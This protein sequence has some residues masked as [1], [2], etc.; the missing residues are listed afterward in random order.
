VTPETCTTQRITHLRRNWSC[1][2]SVNSCSS[3]GST[4]GVAR[5]DGHPPPDLGRPPCRPSNI[6]P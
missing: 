6:P 3:G 5:G 2:G 1:Y 4:T